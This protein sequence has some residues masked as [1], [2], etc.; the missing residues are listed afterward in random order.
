MSESGQR[1]DQAPH[2]PGLTPTQEGKAVLVFTVR[3]ALDQVGE[4]P[5]GIP[6]GIQKPGQKPGGGFHGLWIGGRRFAQDVSGFCGGVDVYRVK[7]F[8]MYLGNRILVEEN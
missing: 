6:E 1:T 7:A 8:G 3:V 4:T 5:V 2:R